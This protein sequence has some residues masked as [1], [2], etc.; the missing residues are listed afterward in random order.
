MDFWKLLFMQCTWMKTS[1]KVL[2]LK[3]HHVAIKLVSQKKESTP[4]HWNESTFKNESQAVS[5]WH[6]HEILTYCLPTCWSFRIGLNE[7][8]YSFFATRCS[9]FSSKNSCFPSKAVHKADLSWQTLL[10]QPLQA[11]WHGNETNWTNHCKLAWR[12]GG[13]V[14]FNRWTNRLGVVEP[15][16]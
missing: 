6:N 14:K 2:H 11:W 4:N 10:D 16:R 12:K 9:F 1:C 7:N 5:C 13:S 3:V 15:E 8:A